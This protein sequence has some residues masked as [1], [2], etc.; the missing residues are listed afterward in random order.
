MADTD[1]CAGV[2]WRKSSLSAENGNCVEVAEL[3]DGNIGVRDSK[4]NAPGC[5]VLT[6]TRAEW[7]TFLM[8]LQ[9]GHFDLS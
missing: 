1:R 7:S 2:Y 4:D 6:F 5:P 8:G 3:L 9:E